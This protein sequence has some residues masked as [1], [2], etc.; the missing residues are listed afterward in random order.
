M[1][2]LDALYPILR[3]LIAFKTVS[4]TNNLALIDYLKHFFEDLGFSCERL[5][6]SEGN[7]RANLLCQIGPQVPGGLMLSGHTDVVPTDGQ[8]WLSDP[9]DLKDAGDRFIGRGTADMKGFIASTCVALRLLNLTKLKKPLTLL[10]TYDEEIGALGS[11][12]AAKELANYCKYLPESVLIGEPTSFNIYSKHAGHVTLSISARGKGAHSSDPALGIS[13]I[14]ALVSVLQGIFALEAELRAEIIDD[15]HFKRPFVTLNVG[16]IEGGTAVNIIPDQAKALIGFRPLPQTPV[17]RLLERIERIVR[18]HQTPG[19]SFEI[20]QPQILP[21][22]VTAPGTRLENILLP[23]AASRTRGAAAFATDAGNLNELGIQC[24]IFGPG[25]IDVA[26]QANEW[27]AKS[28]V[29]QAIEK[30]AHIVQA[31]LY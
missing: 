11:K 15:P 17:P 13:A 2:H 25:S 4:G 10:W 5:Y 14:K 12:A 1:D 19:V 28:D 3:D 9:W 23:L 7:K 29:E 30:I 31:Y 26:H 8:Q 20:S 21:A 18:E 22:M 27:I 16:Q 24:L 6:A